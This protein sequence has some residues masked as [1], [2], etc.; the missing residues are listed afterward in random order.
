MIIN[1]YWKIA[2][3]TNPEHVLIIS[4]IEG[5]SGCWSYE[6]SSFKT[7]EWARACIE[8]SLDINAVANALFDAGVNKVTIKD[9]HRTGYNLLS[10]LIDPRARIIPGYIK[11]PVPGLGDPEDSDV[12]ML[13]G[14]HAASGTDGFLAHTFTSRIASLDVNGRLMAEVELFSASLSPFNLRPVF[15]SGCPVACKQAEEAVRDICTYPID[16][17]GGPGNFD[18][19][20]W[21]AGLANAAVVSLDNT[22]IKPYL[23]AGPFDVTITMRDGE[24]AAKKIAAKWGLRREHNKIFLNA[25]DIHQ[26][27]NDLIRICYLSP[28]VEKIITPALFLYNLWARLGLSWVRRRVK[29]AIDVSQN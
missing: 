22:N 2:M 10:E 29:P 7:D 24:I 1:N 16:K 18:V 28:F 23:P 3:T 8:M 17:F 20:A 13:M 14:M 11:G 5:S 15:F 12:L 25:P 6:A 21:R 19:A 26:L 27:H 4:D 9:F